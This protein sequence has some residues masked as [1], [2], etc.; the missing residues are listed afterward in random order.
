[1]KPL[2]SAPFVA[3]FL[4][5]TA[6]TVAIIRVPD[7]LRVMIATKRAHCGDGPLFVV[8]VLPGG[9]VRLNAE[10]MPR[11]RLGRR[12]HEAFETIAER[13]V[14]IKA[15]P[16]VPF[17]D[18]A[19]AISAS[20]DQADYVALLTPGVEKRPGSCLGIALPTFRDYYGRRPNVE[21]K[22]VPLWRALWPW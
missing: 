16:D 13:L 15:D 14:F 1:M 3:L 8:D 18:V 5:L 21:M 7:G 12:L 10:Q 4:I 9:Q 6:I 11:D 2:N 19:D 20:L 17:R 22:E